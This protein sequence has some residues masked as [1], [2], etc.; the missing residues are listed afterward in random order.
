MVLHRLRENAGAHLRAIE[1]L[2]KFPENS[3]VYSV[4][5]SDPERFAYLLI[6]GH[7]SA[8]GKPPTVI[9]GGCAESAGELLHHLP[10]GPYTIHETPRGFLTVLESKIPAESKVYH[11]RRMELRRGGFKAVDSSSARKLMVSDDV[12]LADFFGALPHAAGGMRRWIEGAQCLLGIFEDSKLVAMGSTF[13]AVPEG[14]SLVSIKTRESH[15]RRGL[16]AQV[17]SALC[18]EAF[19]HVDVVELTVL[20]DNSPAIALYQKLGFELKEERVWVDCGSG[21]SPYF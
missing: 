21:S 15:R 18:V 16:A 2:T 7:P 6:S 14:W 1:D 3:K 4:H 20:S 12:A 17:T 10:D 9:L 19:K 5:E 8:R 13:C 11:E